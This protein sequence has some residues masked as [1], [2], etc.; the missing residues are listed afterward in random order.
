MVLLN[1]I[2]FNC[3]AFSPQ[4]QSGFFLRDFRRKNNC[5]H[6][7][8][9]SLSIRCDYFVLLLFWLR[10]YCLRNLLSFSKN[11]PKLFHPPF[12]FPVLFLRSFRLAICFFV[13][14]HRWTAPSPI[15]HGTF[16]EN[17]FVESS[18]LGCMYLGVFLHWVLEAHVRLQRS[19][20]ISDSRRR[21]AKEIWALICAK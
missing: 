7:T 12:P 13:P 1:I 4:F 16:N 5:F 11:S 3:L 21:E 19:L 9:Y 6:V 20:Q 17:E 15:F 2:Q 14:I 8:A 10:D 18:I